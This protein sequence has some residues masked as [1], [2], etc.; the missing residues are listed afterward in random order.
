MTKMEKP[1]KYLDG[2][3]LIYSISVIILGGLLSNIS[4]I[5]L[6]SVVKIILNNQINQHLYTFL[7]IILEDISILTIVLIFKNPKIYFKGDFWQTLK[8]SSVYILNLLNLAIFAVYSAIKENLEF[9]TNIEILLNIFKLISI[10]FFEESLFRGLIANAFAKK[11]ILEKNEKYGILKSIVYTSLIFGITHII[12]IFTANVNISAATVQ[13]LNAI[14]IG[15]IFT[16]IYYRGGNILVPII[17]HT[18]TNFYGLFRAYFLN[19]KDY[20][21]ETDLINARD[22]S[23]DFHICIM[24]F[25]I[26]AVYVSFLIRKSKINDIKNTVE[27]INS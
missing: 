5:I 16:T 21:T 15:G 22:V 1:L 14:C 4:A 25:L 10:S 2:H 18:L 3:T 27:T 12:N 17:V 7:K 13:I 9:K 20:T 19:I 23:R 26:T 11:H 8:I 24:L 6:S